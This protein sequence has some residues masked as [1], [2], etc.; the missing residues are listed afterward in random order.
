[1]LS[2][3]K[4]STVALVAAFSIVILFGS[5]DFLSA[6]SIYNQSSTGAMHQNDDHDTQ[7]MMGGGMM[8]HMGGMMGSKLMH[9]GGNHSHYG[10]SM[11][12]GNGSSN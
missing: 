11:M 7:G 10:G 9:H 8:K 6:H 12:M 3:R 1:M 4:I 5:H 2:F